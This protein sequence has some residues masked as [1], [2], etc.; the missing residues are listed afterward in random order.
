M[1]II[2]IQKISL[3]LLILCLFSANLRAEEVAELPDWKADTLTGDWGATRTNLYKSGVEIGI[4]HKSDVLANVSGGLKRGSAWLGHTELRADFDLEKLFDWDSTNFALLYHSDLGSKFNTNYVGSVAGVDNIEVATNTAQFFYA[5]LQKTFFADK[6]SILFGMYSV[7]SVFYVTDSSGL[8]IQSPLGISTELAATGLNGVPAFPVGALMLHTKAYS[9][10][11]NFYAQAAVADGVPGDPDNPRGTYV[12]LGNGDGTLSIIELG[13]QPKNAD[14]EAEHFNKTAIGFWRYSTKFDDIDGLG[15]R[16]KSQGAY[17]LSEQ[18]FF[19]ESGSKSQ[20]LTGFVRF[21]VANEQVNAID[22]S[23]SLG[24]HYRGLIAGR[25][26]D[27]TGIAVTVTHAG[28]DFRSTG[29]FKR[30]ETGFELTY[31]AQIKPW[32]AIQPTI[33]G[34][35]NTGLDLTINDAWV[36]GTRIELE[37]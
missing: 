11:K 4:T 26:N 29:D 9:P 32:L 7:D 10:N 25:D 16:G 3:S 19:H 33:Q 31:R 12:K 20:G 1:G 5:Y 13:Y 28:S 21:G 30:Q 23:G 35:F 17:V 8:F 34:V 37:L 27:E 22:W 15:G 6:L 24:L 36:V 14:E 2:N 18:T